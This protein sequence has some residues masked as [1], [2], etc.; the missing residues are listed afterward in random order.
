MR[1]PASGLRIHR[2]A[3]RPGLDRGRPE[4]GA[5]D[6]P[7]TVAEAR[8]LWWLVDRPNAMI[9]IP[10][11][12]AGLPAVRACL[13]EGV[14]GNATPHFSGGRDRAGKARLLDSNEL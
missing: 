8:L 13:A 4:L 1:H 2:G 3:G 14:S 9:K 7:R 12:S 11:T 5:D 6:T 10:A